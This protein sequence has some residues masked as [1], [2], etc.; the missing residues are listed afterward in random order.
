MFLAQQATLVFVGSL[1][2]RIQSDVVEF[3]VESQ[4]HFSRL[5]Q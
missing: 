2:S 3:Y 5:R 1:L 4:R